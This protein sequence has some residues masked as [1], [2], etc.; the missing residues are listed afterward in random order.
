MSSFLSFLRA[1]TSSSPK[2]LH[3]LR[4]AAT[5]MTGGEDNAQG[6]RTVGGRGGFLGGLRELLCIGRPSTS[7]ESDD[8]RERRR[9]RAQR[10]HHSHNTS[11]HRDRVSSRPHGK[12]RTQSRPGRRRSSST[13]IRRD[14]NARSAHQPRDRYDRHRPRHRR[15]DPVRPSRHRSWQVGET[16]EPD[17]GQNLMLNIAWEQPEHRAAM[18]PDRRRRILR[19]RTERCCRAQ[20]APRVVEAPAQNSP[21]T[22]TQCVSRGHATSR[23]EPRV[24]EGPPPDSDDLDE[25][26]LF[27]RIYQEERALDPVLRSLNASGHAKG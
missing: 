8:R 26:Q 6:Q 19:P 23:R 7:K 22:V 27:M 2:P 5:L 11:G 16:P 13:N 18:V 3:L 17:L 12:R 10:R 9:R 24:P 15:V 1:I 25:E 21:L 4:G 20:H 14:R